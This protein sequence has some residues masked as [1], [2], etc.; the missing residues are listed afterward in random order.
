[1]QRREERARFDDEGPASDLLD[2]LRDRQAVP[3][4]ERERAENQEV[5]GPF[6]ELGSTRAQRA[7]FSDLEGSGD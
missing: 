1:M 5:Q 6:Q 4:F 2:A 7:S 3:R